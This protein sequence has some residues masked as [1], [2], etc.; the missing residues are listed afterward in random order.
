MWH[1]HTVIDKYT[2]P[3]TLGMVLKPHT[4]KSYKELHYTGTRV[5][6]ITRNSEITA[7]SVVSAA[8]SFVAV[9]TNA[10]LM[11]SAKDRITK[12]SVVKLALLQD[13]SLIF[14]LETTCYNLN[15]GRTPTQ[16]HQWRWK[17]RRFAFSGLDHHK[18]HHCASLCK[19]A[20][21]SLRQITQTGELY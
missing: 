18:A 11:I 6:I 7:C 9:E 21:E 5:I 2:N 8:I 1:K 16:A 4:H 20:M 12:T 14:L 15:R 13:Y 17:W 10:E 19:Q 3:D